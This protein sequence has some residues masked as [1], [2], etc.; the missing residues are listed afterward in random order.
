MNPKASIVVPSLGRYERLKQCIQSVLDQQTPFDFEVIVV[1]DGPD[2]ASIG[3]KLSTE[4]GSTRLRFDVSSERRGSP[5]AKNAGAGLA[6]GEVLVFV[7]DDV[8][9][10]K[11]WLETL[12]AGYSHGV[13]G[14]GGSEAKPRDPGLMR[15]LWL[16]LLG[17][18]TGIVT[19]SGQVVSNFSPTK[20][21]VEEVQCLAGANMSFAKVLFDQVGG[22]DVGYL[23]TSYREETDLC[24]RFRGENKLLF[25]P[26]AVV[27]HFEEGVGGNTPESLREWNY[28]Y[29]RNNTYFFLKNE[30]L[31]NLSNWWSHLASE[32]LLASGRVLMQ[33][34]F[35]PISTMRRGIRDGRVAIEEK[36]RHLGSGVVA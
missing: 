28:W 16:K 20:T 19:W 10:R 22:F 25:V 9:A 27:D 35:T 34:S 14:V 12:I 15:S 24:A 23:G 33:R 6:K 13:A 30:G 3:E 31:L 5:R 21:E 1:I 7:D 32:I 36:Q 17:S 26:T 18:P 8:V 29:H 2:S 11:G 4:M